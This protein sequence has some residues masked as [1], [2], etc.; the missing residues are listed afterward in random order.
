[1]KT[2]SIMPKLTVILIVV[3]AFTLW[4]YG[5]ETRSEPLGAVNV[6][7]GVYFVG[8]YGCNIAAS[9]GPDGVLIIDSGYENRTG[10]ILS[11]LR[12]LANAAVSIVMD[13][14]FHFD[15]VGGNEAF[16][17]Q[18]AV[19]ISQEQARAR[20]TMPWNVKI[21]DV[22]WPKLQPYPAAALAKV[23]YRDSL[24]VHFNNDE[25][26][27]LHLPAAHSDSDV[28]IRFKKANFIHTGDLFLSN[29]FTVIDLDAGGTVDGYLAAVDKI[30]SL[31]DS[32][33]VVMPGHG[34]VSNREGLQSYRYMLTAAKDRIAA[35]I[36]EGKTLEEVVAADVTAGLFKGG[37]SWL[38][39][40]LY[41]YCA[42]TDLTR[43]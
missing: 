26:E 36:R 16:A 24:R 30:I 25:I 41:V 43:H 38:D 35:L 33:T 27:A 17:R 5:Q 40:K 10:Q 8:N 18:G 1:M 42:Y 13:T 12:E 22:Q 31:C 14:H 20:M 6:A 37:K 11:A 4:G 19:I 9:I 23:D 15:H 3:S 28:V 7:K 21:L 39:P 32:S 34:P 29:G 2:N